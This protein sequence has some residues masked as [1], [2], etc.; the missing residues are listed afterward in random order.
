[1][2]LTSIIIW[3]GDNF[4]EVV[5]AILPVNSEIKIVL[6]NKRLTLRDEEMSFNRVILVDDMVKVPN[7]ENNEEEESE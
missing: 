4:R 3:T 2:Q 6:K 5:Q 1:M 7:R